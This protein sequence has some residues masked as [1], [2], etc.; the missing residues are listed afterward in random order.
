MATPYWWRN[1]LIFLVAVAAAV[2]GYLIF[3]RFLRIAA[4]IILLAAVLTYLLQPVVEWLVHFS[5]TQYRHGLRVGAVLL[6]YVLLAGLFYT[7]GAAIARPFVQDAGAL[8]ETW[9]TARQHIPEQLIRLQG[10]YDHTVPAHIRFQITEAIQKEINLFPDKYVPQ[11]AAVFMGVVK[12]AGAWIA[13]IIELIFVPLVA[14]YFLT[15]ARKVREQVLFFVPRRHRANVERYSGGMNTILKEYI[16]GQLILCAIAWVVVTL[17]MLIMGVP[18]ALLLGVIAG[19]SRAI[20]V[21]GPVVGGIPVL[22]AVL[23]TPDMAGAFWWVLIGFSSLHLFESKVLMPKILGT[24][25]NI[26]PVLIVISLL[27]GYQI[28]GLLGM[29]IAPPVLAIVRFMLAVRRGEGPFA[30]SEQL[31]LPAFKGAPSPAAGEPL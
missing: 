30:S 6:L 12:K 9:N 23:F 10:W 8:R 7:F 5:K 1:A 19:L 22:A 27:V 14:F 16:R 18:G 28:L 25:L 11:A 17:A 26:H 20:P 13:M 3:E 29:F 24:Y 21:I 4:T 31:E 15:D 2:V